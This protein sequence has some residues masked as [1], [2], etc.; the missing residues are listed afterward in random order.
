MESLSSIVDRR[1]AYIAGHSRRVRDLA[2]PMAR[3][4]GVSAAELAVLAQA[5]LFHDIGKLTV[6]DA[7]LLKKGPLTDEETAVMRRHA[8]EGARIIE[9]LGFLDDAVPLIRHHHEH[10]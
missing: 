10:V 7:I 8:D 4:L 2:L 3:E 1:D 5:A 9:R 6:P